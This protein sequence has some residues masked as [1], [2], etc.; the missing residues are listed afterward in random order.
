MQPE[1]R[2]ISITMLKASTAAESEIADA[3]RS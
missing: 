2:F 3:L 1:F